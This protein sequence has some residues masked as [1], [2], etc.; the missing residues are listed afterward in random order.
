MDQIRIDNLKLFGKHGVEEKERR[1]KQEFTISVLLDFKTRKAGLSDRLA[2]TIDYTKTRDTIREIIEGK[3]YRL[4]ESLA[5]KMCFEIL[6]DKRVRAVELSIAK[7]TMWKNGT[8]GITIR[9]GR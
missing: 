2:D 4:I 6:K 3:S 1:T 7:T 9:R 8:P 5:E